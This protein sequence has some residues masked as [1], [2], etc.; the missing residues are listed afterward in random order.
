MK[1]AFLMNC[2]QDLQQAIR[3]LRLLAEFYPASDRLLYLDGKD[4]AESELAAMRSLVQFCERR[5]YQP[6]K[7]DG[8]LGALNRLVEIAAS[9]GYGVASFLHADMIPIDRDC[10]ETFLQ[11]FVES[12]KMLTYTPM[13]PCSVYASF[14]DLHFRLPKAMSLFPVGRRKLPENWGISNEAFLTA[15]FNEKSPGWQHRAYHLLTIVRPY[16]GESNPSKHGHMHE[17]EWVF[18]NWTPETSVV[19][20][21]DEDFWNRYH[22]FAR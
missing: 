19:H 4:Y 13:W 15:S 10:F 18:H 6:D 7:I 2:H 1:H 21:N 14:C 12:N 3:C 22:K 8:T 17:C 9:G 20:A 16:T 11:R 5:H